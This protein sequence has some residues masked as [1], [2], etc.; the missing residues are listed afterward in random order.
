[1]MIFYFFFPETVMI[2]F[3]ISCKWYQETDNSHE[4][5]SPVFLEKKNNTDIRDIYTIL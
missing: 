5:P 3:Y 4:M 1:M 2:D